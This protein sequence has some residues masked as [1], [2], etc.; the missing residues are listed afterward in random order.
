MR[1]RLGSRT[2]LGTLAAALICAHAAPVNAFTEGSFERTLQVSGTVNLAVETG[3]GSIEI[4]TGPSGQIYVVGRIRSN[5]NWFGPSPEEKIRRIEANPPIQ[6]SGSDVRIGHI[7]E[8]EL[9]RNVAISFEITVP[10]DSRVRSRSGSGSQTVEGTRGTLEIET[11]SGDVKIRN[12]GSA[13]RASTGSG[14]IEAD[15]IEGNMRAKTGSGSIRATGIAGGLEADTG[16]GNIRLEQTASGAV[17][18]E[19]GSGSIELKGVH[20]SLDAKTGSGGVDADGDPTGTWTVHTGSG[21]VHLRLPS[22]ASFDLDAETSSGS[23]SVN[24]PI[25]V[26]GSIGKKEVRGKVRGGGVPIE[27]RTGSGSVEIL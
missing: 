7:E 16:S 20:G 22:N 2:F 27:V 14:S 13:V 10:A 17:R 12:I 21:T 24:H 23:V 26:T 8:P 18:V 1:L 6:Q 19:A 4:R 25:T 11:G 15:H 5:G 3:S 9:R